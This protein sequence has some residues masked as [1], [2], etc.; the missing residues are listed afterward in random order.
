[1]RKLFSLSMICLLTLT[2]TACQQDKNSAKNSASTQSI[3]IAKKESSTK[4]LSYAGSIMP[5]TTR[6]VTSPDEGTIKTK[7]FEYGALIKK[8]QLIFVVKSDKSQTDFT[9][10]LTKYLSAKNSYSESQSALTNQSELYKDGLISQN[11]YQS[12]QDTY[13]NDYIALLQ[14]KNALAAILAKRP[15]IKL[16][17]ETLELKDVDVL[18]KLIGNT[19]QENLIRVYAPT[20]GVA[21]LPDKNTTSGSDSGSS[22]SGSTGP[23]Q[24]GSSVKENQTILSLGNL[25]GLLVNVDINEI[26][27]NQVVKGLPATVTSIALPG[28][29]LQGHVDAVGSQAKAGDGGI[30][31]FAVNIVVPTLTPAQQQLIRVGMSA[32]V[33]III[34]L[35]AEIKVPIAAVKT[36][37][38]GSFVNIPQADGTFKSTAVQTGETG[39]SDVSIISG[40]KEGDKVAVPY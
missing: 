23:I 40:L 3:A 17:I 8:S 4:T 6:V 28:L 5:V 2:V 12:A 10:A 9:S 18:S 22:D 33:Q 27:I 16:N 34:S 35:P 32:K 37:N 14:A 39:I 31:T 19:H 29:I 20:D 25:S 15:D 24:P 30:P 36:T 7:N 21:L 38:Q 26:N 1:M 13:Y 11:S